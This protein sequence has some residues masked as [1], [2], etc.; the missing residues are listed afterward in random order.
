MTRTKL[1]NGITYN[2]YLTI[3]EQCRELLITYLFNTNPAFTVDSDGNRVPAP[4]RYLVIAVDEDL[5]ANAYTF[6]T[7]ED[8]YRCGDRRKNSMGPAPYNP[9]RSQVK[10]HEDYQLPYEPDS[11]ELT[12]KI[13]RAL[14][15]I[16]L[17]LK[18]YIIA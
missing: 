18:Q 1:K 12:M 4:P 17:K 7:K 11:P 14:S 3:L 16:S 15:E 2:R 8:Y 6:K 10:L 9:L 13:S 5:E